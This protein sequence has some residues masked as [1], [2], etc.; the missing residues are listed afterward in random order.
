[1]AGNPTISTLE[2]G[3]TKLAL[4]GVDGITSAPPGGTLTFAGLDTVLLATQGGPIV[5]GSEI[6][7]QNIQNL[8]F[9]ARGVDAA[10]TLGWSITGV[11]RLRLDSEGSVQVN[12][13]ISADS[14]KTFSNGDFLQGSSTITANVIRIDSVNGN[15]T[16]YAS[17]LPDPASGGTIELDAGATLNI[18]DPSGGGPTK[19]SSIVANGNTIN[20][21][22]PSL[23]TF[24]FSNSNLILFG[25]GS[26]GLHAPNVNFLGPNFIALSG[27]DINIFGAELPMLNGDKPFSGLIDAS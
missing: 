3:V 24:D 21:I 20:F 11:S 5:L 17:K 14:L 18:L 7:F 1:L 12:G 6:S 2:S 22:S 13:N 10:L 25:A 15:I 8:V 27:A 9:Y 16:V 26:G 4:V 19:R 23:F